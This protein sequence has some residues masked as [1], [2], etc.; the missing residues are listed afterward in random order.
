MAETEITVQVFND[1]NEIEKVVRAS[2]FE[3]VR[4]FEMRDR[5]FTKLSDPKA[6]AYEELLNA[7]LIIREV[8]EN[9][10]MVT[11]LLHKKKTFDEAGNVISE[12]KFKTPLTDA[13]SAATVLEMSGLERWCTVRNSSVVY[14]NK[15][16]DEFALQK[17]IGLG[18]FIEWEADEKLAEKLTPEAVFV[19]LKKKVSALGL[20]LGEDYSCKKPFMILHNGDGSASS[21]E[22]N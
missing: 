17:I 18:T 12:E 9:N 7:S 22:N 20:R 6:A 19:V 8:A 14:K 4:K 1:P 10:V 16:G 5:Y 11:A 3:P 13:D 15:D 2:G 21:K